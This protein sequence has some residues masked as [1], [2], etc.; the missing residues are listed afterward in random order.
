[1]ELIAKEKGTALTPAAPLSSVNGPDGAVSSQNGGEL[2]GSGHR[3]VDVTRKNVPFRDHRWC[4]GLAF[5]LLAHATVVVA[6]WHRARSEPV[7]LRLSA[8][9]VSRIE[10]VVVARPDITLGAHDGARLP[11]LFHV[12][13]V[14]RALLA[15]D[16][17]FL[18]DRFPQVDVDLIHEIQER[19]GAVLVRVRLELSEAAAAEVVASQHAHQHHGQQ[20]HPHHHRRSGCEPSAACTAGLVAHRFLLS[21]FIATPTYSGY[22][23]AVRKE[24]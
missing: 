14:L 16:G 18:G 7:D 11:R 13:G 2:G 3:S 17:R 1:M 10:R 20:R 8:H 15:D 23:N 4:P 19:L 22:N 21:E 6:G 9:A 12:G 5:C 24:S